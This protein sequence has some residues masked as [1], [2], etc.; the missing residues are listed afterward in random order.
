MVD[1]REGKCPQEAILLSTH[2][3]FIHNEWPALGAGMLFVH[4]SSDSGSLLS[5]PNASHVPDIFV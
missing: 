3:R 2:S 4:F 1:E 5:K